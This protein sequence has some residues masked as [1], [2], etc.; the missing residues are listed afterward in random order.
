MN[1]STEDQIV[2]SR[3]RGAA[4][5]LKG[6]D[7]ML[8]SVMARLEVSPAPRVRRRLLQPW[9]V[10]TLAAA[11]AVAAL[12]LGAWFVVVGTSTTALAYADVVKA[13]EKVRS[14]HLVSQGVKPGESMSCTYERGVGIRVEGVMDGAKLLIVDNGK[15]QWT[16]Q[17]TGDVKESDSEGLMEQFTKLLLGNDYLDGARR[18]RAG[19]ETIDG[20]R[21]RLFVKTPSENQPGTRVWLD[22]DDR[23]RRM[24]IGRVKD[25]KW[26]AEQNGSVR[27][28]MPVDR[29]L[30]DAP[31]APGGAKPIDLRALAAQQFSPD[32]VL[33]KAEALGM[34]LM[35]HDLRR[36]DDG[37]LLVRSSLRPTEETLKRFGSGGPGAH[38]IGDFFL[39]SPDPARYSV[40]PVAEYMSG[41]LLVKWDLLV[42][43]SPQKAGKTVTLET[44]L[45]AQDFEFMESFTRQKK[46]DYVN[47]VPVGAV[48]IPTDQR[49]PVDELITS[50][51]TTCKS[52]NSIFTPVNMAEATRLHPNG[53][54]SME[55]TGIAK[56][57]AE[58][59]LSEVKQ[60]VRTRREG[61]IQRQRAVRNRD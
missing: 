56:W 10:R 23:V 36:G 25:G 45:G 37:T 48:P 32:H 39:E 5:Q 6:E 52:L 38:P 34:I 21:C 13:L 49:A 11:A 35:V 17:G 2:E 30:F 40:V 44:R 43:L 7:S 8:E 22:D 42:P 29:K 4:E 18:D 60:E 41:R 58:R 55:T 15:R 59:L 3:L 20:V 53:K 1:T 19:D 16:R 33:A 50:V 46:D 9:A 54:R 27:Y 31:V 24:E 51:W 47:D 14:A 57:T 61:D 28:D 12:A 26:V